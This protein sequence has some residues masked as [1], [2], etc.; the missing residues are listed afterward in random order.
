[1]R[2]DGT[3]DLVFVPKDPG[4]QNYRVVFNVAEGAVRAFKSGRLPQ[5]M[6]DT[7]CESE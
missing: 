1:M 2:I 7:G 6:L 4:D 5:V 3:V